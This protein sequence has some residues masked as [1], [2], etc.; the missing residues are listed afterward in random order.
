MRNWLIFLA[1]VGP[2]A[3]ALHFFEVSPVLT[4]LFSAAALVPLGAIME[5]STEEVADHLGPT[6]G[7]LLNATLGNAPELIIS[8]MALSKG[9][10]DV[11]KA[12]I[13]GSILGNLL[14]ANGI[15][16]IFGGW[17]RPAQK[18]NAQA[19][20]L[21]A[22]LLTL[23]IVA[24]IVP[25]MFEHT[26][27]SDTEISIQVAVVQIAVY[28]CSLF[29]LLSR[30]PGK[31]L[32]DRGLHH[33]IPEEP[34]EV[35]ESLWRPLG[36]LAIATLGVAFMS[37]ILTDAI[38]PTAK[39]LGLTTTFTGVFLLASAGNIAQTF[40][41]VQFARGDNME[42]TLSTT[43]G[44]STQVALLV[45]PVL[46]FVSL[47]FG[48]PMN[49]IFSQ[50]ELFGLLVATTV[51]RNV[52]SDGICNWMEGVLLVGVYALLGIAFFAA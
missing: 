10:Q 29:Y 34:G 30:Q 15:S 50:L 52:T 19:A 4:F 5:D 44:S 46:V 8:C 51:I 35:K 11:V 20:G 2:L 6:I 17:G 26:T 13:T 3:I 39:N 27:T 31:A 41:A 43:V 21:N 7:G 33:P 28:L 40:N 38:E 24:L 37:E 23:S 36:I 49:L 14:F 22:G 16:M 45:A 32:P 25:A 1:V 42:L 47:A 18:F 12:S 48:N 9:L